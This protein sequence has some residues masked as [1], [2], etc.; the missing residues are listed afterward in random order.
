MFF[1]KEDIQKIH[2]ALLQYGVKDTQLPKTSTNNRDDSLVIVQDGINKNIKVIDFL[3]QISLFNKEAFINL[4]ELTGRSY[5]T[6][7]EAIH[8]VP[9]IRRCSGLVITYQDTNTNWQI[10]QFRGELNQFD[11][12]TFWINLYDFTPYIVDS[13]LPDEEDLT[14]SRIDNSGNN[15]MSLKDREY[16]KSEFSGKGYKILRKNIKKFDYKVITLTFSQLPTASGNINF[17]INGNKITVSIDST[18]DN[19]LSKVNTKLIT[20]FSTALSSEYS[21]SKVEDSVINIKYETKIHSTRSY[22]SFH[23]TGVNF[24]L[25]T[26][27]YVLRKN[28]LTQDMINESNTVYEI[29]YDFDL[30]N[31]EISIKDECTLNFVGGSLS[32]GILNGNKVQ[33]IND[34]VYKIF[35]NL[36]TN[37]RTLIKN[38]IIYAEWFGAKDDYNYDN[39]IIK[40][41][42]AKAIE[43]ATSNFG[44]GK[45]LKFYG[46]NCFYTSK[47]I[48]MKNI[49]NIIGSIDT[50]IVT[51]SGVFSTK[52]FFKE[53]LIEN[54]CIDFNYRYGNRSIRNISFDFNS[55]EYGITSTANSLSNIKIDNVVLI[56]AK[57]NI[58]IKLGKGDFNFSYGASKLDINRLSSKNCINAIYIDNDNDNSA[59]TSNTYRYVNFIKVAN[60]DIS[61]CLNGI[62]IKTNISIETTEF[63]RINFHN[64]GFNNYS[65]DNYNNYGCS[66][67]TIYN[68]MNP[69]YSYKGYIKCSNCYFENIFPYREGTD[70]LEDE[71]VLGNK[72]YP[73]DFSKFGVFKLYNTT[74]DIENCY[75]TNFKRT[76]ILSNSAGIY[77]KT[78]MFGN[79]NDW[80]NTILEDKYLC[81]NEDDFV[82]SPA[83]IIYDNILVNYI[84]NNNKNLIYF[85][86]EKN[87]NK[88]NVKLNNAINDFKNKVLHVN[89]SKFKIIAPKGISCFKIVTYVE[90]YNINNTILN[91]I[92]NDS[93]KYVKVSGDNY[94]LHNKIYI[95]KSKNNIEIYIKAQGIYIDIYSNTDN[96][97]NLSENIKEYTDDITFKKTPFC[98]QCIEENIND[99][100]IYSKLEHYFIEDINTH[101][102]YHG[103]DTLKFDIYGNPYNTKYYGTHLERPNGKFGGQEYVESDK[104]ITYRW[105]LNK[106][107]YDTLGNPASASKK[108]TT[109]QR[110]TGI[111]IGFIYKDTELN[112][113]IIWNGEAW[114]NIDGT[115]L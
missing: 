84:D 71:L 89:K 97:Y 30:N 86:N 105:I 18:T 51:F 111:Q 26:E 24:V 3:S 44:V 93:G 77:I 33:I 70:K 65:N 10:Y 78:N 113:W 37:S 108:G 34:S 114:E 32:N 59:T 50:P 17:F 73:K 8:N 112:K 2:D 91:I 31:E 22:V 85:K 57:N 13:T 83:K 100:T 101:K 11:T 81:Y 41:D 19:T 98:T 107:W 92:D 99:S 43:M 5:S 46:V 53:N 16:N 63:E 25:N 39:K 79:A 56:N 15:Y 69:T 38:D 1:T 45:T 96:Y 61:N 52:I 9:Y 4:T 12:I 28:I 94:F 95:D 27:D 23:N 76:F 58:Y 82:N 54:Y 87:L 7:D 62:I 55:N 115:A 72:I 21:V 88:Y 68:N 74:L 109:A 49:D 102:L 36:Q 42:S 29:R 20:A 90:N 40:T 67:I 110:P 66:A 75:F 48:S 60:S 64:I 80:M 14:I 47:P 35:D 106:G 6:L 104:N 103:F